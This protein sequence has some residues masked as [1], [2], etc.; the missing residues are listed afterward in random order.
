MT[1]MKK[2]KNIMGYIRISQART[3]SAAL[4][5]SVVCLIGAS[6]CTSGPEPVAP[7][8]TPPAALSTTHAE[9]SANPAQMAAERVKSR[10]DPM[11]AQ[12]L[13][14]HG[15]GTK[16]PCRPSAETLFGEKCLAAATSIGSIAGA[17]LAEIKGVA[18]PGFATLRQASSHTVAAVGGY[19][20]LG[21]ADNPTDPSTRSKCVDHASVIAQAPTDLADGLRLGLIGQ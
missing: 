6:A 7:V 18:K 3:T 11:I 19:T 12:H 2:R 9:E 21:C 10:V 17:A 5:L 13:T 14:T 8:V 20:E 15:E 4:A 1:P 16:S